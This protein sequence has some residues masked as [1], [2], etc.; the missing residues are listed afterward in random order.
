V[1]GFAFAIDGELKGADVY[2][3]NELFKQLWPRLLKAAAV[4]AIS[5]PKSVSNPV[6]IE[7]VGAFLVNSE[8]GLE[9]VRD[10]NWRTR[11]AERSTDDALFLECRDTYYHDAWVH[12]SYLARKH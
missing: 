4:E 1:I 9:T 12:R 2:S 7:T 10:I 8:L 5:T 3:S 11:S 6:P